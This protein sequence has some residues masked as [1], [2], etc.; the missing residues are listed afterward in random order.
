MP[1]YSYLQKRCLL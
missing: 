1:I